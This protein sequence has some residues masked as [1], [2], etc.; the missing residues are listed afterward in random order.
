MTDRM[1]VFCLLTL[2]SCLGCSQPQEGGQATAGADDRPNI[3][4]IVAD[5][6]G[7]TDLG[8]FGS[9][10]S[11]PN[12]DGIAR[13]GML[14]TQFHAAP[15]CSVTR[16]M[17]LSGNNNHVAGVAK[18][19]GFGLAG[20]P[21]QGYEGS[22][23]D[24][25]MPFPKLLRDSGYHTYTVGKWHLGMDEDNSP[26][27]A[28]F[29]RSFTLLGGAGSHFD[30]TGMREG[31]SK[32][33]EDGQLVEYP[34]GRYSTDFYT[35]KLIEYIA[36]NNGD[37][38]PFFAFAAY[39]SPHWPLQVPDEYLDLYA[40]QYDEGY[41]VLR[42][43]RFESLKEAGI[44]PQSQSL[45]PRNEAVRLWTELSPDEQRVESRKMEIYAAM[46]QN[47]DD[48]V[49]RLI[50][51]LKSAG[52][53]E[54]TLIVFMSDNGADGVDFYASGEFS[55]Y[56]QA[57][58]D[59][60]WDKMGTAESFVSYGRPWAEASS[61]PFHRY[62]GYTRQGGIASPLLVAGPG[63]AASGAID[64]NYMTV[65]DLAPTFLDIA[66]ATYPDDDSVRPMIG[67]SAAAFLAGQ[68]ASVHSDEYVT[69]QYHNG[70]AYL[71]QGNWKLVNLERPF[72]E[73]DFE[74]FDLSTDPGETV[75]LA[76]EEPEKYAELIALWQQKRR[77]MGI[78]LPEDL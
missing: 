37:G 66:G 32:Y 33:R 64:E 1:I 45:P 44:I 50:D 70:R 25:I 20:L 58:Y 77:E 49:G 60:A 61:A 2:I 53:Y 59:N 29:S 28:G 24:R 57:N 10:I 43:R 69:V 62:K 6:L 51:Y 48:H 73:A 72:H 11:T 22:L 15:V 47:L 12:I 65:M 3:L 5:D 9:E 36:S 38:R 35:D 67:E 52:L 75:D 76:M 18:Q 21:V 71:R 55:E 8:I 27:A 68:A 78:I 74:L 34:N 41:D 46:V 63:V 14:L 17:L 54:N 39:T 13:E 4:L 16:A 30:S 26:H 31:G 19:H 40:G 7:Y 23:S 42:E 56:L